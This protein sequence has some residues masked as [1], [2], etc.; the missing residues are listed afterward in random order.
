MQNSLIF[1]P[2]ILLWTIPAA[3]RWH[4]RRLAGQ[5]VSTASGEFVSDGSFSS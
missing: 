2:A 4:R 3:I 1:L 5:A